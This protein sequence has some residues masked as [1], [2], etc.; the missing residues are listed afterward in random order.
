MSIEILTAQEVGELLRLSS[1]RV[2]LMARRGELPCFTLDGHLRFDAGDVE[3]VLGEIDLD[4]ASCPLAQETVRAKRFFT[5]EDDGLRQEWFGRIFLNP[6]YARGVIDRFVEKLLT[7]YLAGK[8]TAAIVLTNSFTDTRWFHALANAGAI[9][10]FTKGRIKF[11]KADGTI[12]HPMRGQSFSYF[13]PSPAS[14]ASEFGRF[15]AVR[16]R[17]RIEAAQR[18]TTRRIAQG[19]AEAK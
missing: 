15:G 6:P 1:N 8:V 14:F 2:I 13:G 4:P 17:Q 10:C 9:F 12:V 3:R 11:Y 5:K 7:E 19:M 18:E 16:P